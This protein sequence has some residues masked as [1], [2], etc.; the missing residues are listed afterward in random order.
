MIV[1][2]NG[3]HVMHLW[4]QYHRDVPDF[5]RGSD[6]LLNIQEN[7]KIVFVSFNLFPPIIGEVKREWG[8]NFPVIWRLI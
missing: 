1:F 7:A 3:R 5:L 2:L 6:V 4:G 8:S